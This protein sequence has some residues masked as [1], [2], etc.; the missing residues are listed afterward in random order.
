MA[1]LYLFT[2]LEK[3]LIRFSPDSVWILEFTRD[4]ISIGSGTR[5]EAQEDQ[6]SNANIPFH[7]L[8]YKVTAGLCLSHESPNL[9]ISRK[10][11]NS[12]VDVN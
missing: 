12:N 1:F 5:E 2:I 4:V 9:P 3:P 7:S 11:G 8:P 10:L 6:P